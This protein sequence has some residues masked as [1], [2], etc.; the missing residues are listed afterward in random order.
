MGA[1]LHMPPPAL[2]SDACRG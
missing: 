2:A 1:V